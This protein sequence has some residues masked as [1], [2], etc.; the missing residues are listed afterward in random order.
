MTIINLKLV[1]FKILQI[2]VPNILK[3]PK[4]NYVNTFLY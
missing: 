4:T 3:I 1:L 2:S